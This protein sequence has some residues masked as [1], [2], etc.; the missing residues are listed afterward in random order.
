[1]AKLSSAPVAFFDSGIGGLA[2]VSSFLE[3]LPNENIVY[4]A[5][6][7]NMPYG[8]KS[9]DE[10]FE[11]VS[12]AIDFFRKFLPK[13]IVI[14]CGTASS[15]VLKKYVDLECLSGNIPILDVVLPACFDSV[16]L[17]RNKKIGVIGTKKTI[18]LGVYREKLKKIDPDL[19]VFCRSCPELA[20]IIE[21]DIYS[22]TGNNNVFSN[23]IKAV[24]K[25][26]LSPF[27]DKNIDTLILGCTHYA[28]VKNCISKYLGPD[29][30]LLDIGHSASIKAV[31]FLIKNKL[32]NTINKSSN[33]TAFLTKE[34]KNFFFKANKI[35]GKY[36]FSDFNVNTVGT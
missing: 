33:F 11:F 2:A 3:K 34:D 23:S 27:D 18:E 36:K 29:I 31:D 22:T 35:L 21:R 9:S 5:D 10:I 25:D 17:T 30:T 20:S 14:A 13:L 32:I 8:N 1:M 7:A 16:K 6:T 19:D 15:V 12:K 26:Y 24:L 28:L 4:F